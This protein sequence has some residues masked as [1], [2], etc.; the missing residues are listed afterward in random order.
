MIIVGDAIWKWAKQTQGAEPRAV[1]ESV[2]KE[3]DVLP[4]NSSG[5]KMWKNEIQ[6]KFPYRPVCYNKSKQTCTLGNTPGKVSRLELMEGLR[7]TLG[8]SISWCHVEHL[9]REIHARAPA[10]AK[11][12]SK[13][14]VSKATFVAAFWP[15]VSKHALYHLIDKEERSDVSSTCVQQ[16]LTEPKQQCNQ[17]PRHDSF[18]ALPSQYSTIDDNDL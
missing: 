10:L 4:Q 12:E 5:C 7:E 17:K 15:F 18:Q 3:I 6:P 16:M 13:G 9:M 14:T 1:L 2:W 11:G 8:L